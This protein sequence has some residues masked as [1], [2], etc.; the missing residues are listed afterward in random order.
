MVKVVGV[1]SKDL[2][3]IG[4]SGKLLWQWVLFNGTERYHCS[5]HMWVKKIAKTLFKS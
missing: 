1:V 3:K 5:F 2:N 4:T